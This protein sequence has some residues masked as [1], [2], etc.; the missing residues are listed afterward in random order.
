MTGR[1]RLCANC[2]YWQPGAPSD[3]RLPIPAE[4]TGDIGAC[5]I[6]FPT[7]FKVDGEP[8]PFQPQ[9]HATRSCAEFRSAFDPGPDEDDDPPD[10]DVGRV[11]TLFPIQPAPLAA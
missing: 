5:E 8:V 1:F 10:P 7:I 3:M 9:T 6:A 2:Y 11:R 4:Q